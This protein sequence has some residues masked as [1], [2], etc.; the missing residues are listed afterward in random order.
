MMIAT[1]RIINILGITRFICISKLVNTNEVIDGK[2]HKITKNTDT[3][4]IIPA[5]VASNKCSF[6]FIIFTHFQ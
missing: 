3:P 5:I 2:D 6:H 1:N 4:I